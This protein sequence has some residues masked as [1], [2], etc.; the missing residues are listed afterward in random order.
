MSYPQPYIVEPESNIAHSATIILLHGR[1]STAEEFASDLF[2]LQTS[3]QN[4]NIRSRFPGFRW[5]FPDAGR[6]WCTPMKEERSA[7]FDTFSLDDLSLRQDLQVPGL[8]DNIG[9][10]KQIVEDE[11]QRLHGKADRVILG[12]FSQGS[13]TALWSL[14][15][16]AAVAKG[17]LGGFIGLGAWM[18]FTREA[19]EAVDDQGGETVGDRTHRLKTKFSAIIG[20]KLL[21]STEL[22]CAGGLQMPVYLGHGKDV[23]SLLENS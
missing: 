6:R 1:S 7:W 11:V 5:V 15:T 2:S 20:I 17:M 9:N 23:H 3:E 12:G 16:G 8:R 18:P 19:K 4:H 22:V 14:F 13:A 21:G 10:I